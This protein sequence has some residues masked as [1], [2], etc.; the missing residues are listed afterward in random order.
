MG[1]PLPI[2][3]SG[4]IARILFLVQEANAWVKE[5]DFLKTINAIRL[6]DLGW[7][8]QFASAEI[9][10]VFEL[11]PEQFVDILIGLLFQSLSFKAIYIK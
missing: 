11:D 6:I 3:R 1:R 9:A 8:M 2:D 10:R 4:F 7:V 5:L